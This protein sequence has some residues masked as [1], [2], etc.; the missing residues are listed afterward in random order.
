MHADREMLRRSVVRMNLWTEFGCPGQNDPQYAEYEARLAEI[1]GKQQTPALPVAPPVDTVPADCV[2]ALRTK[3]GAL[4]LPWGPYLDPASVNRMRG[5]LV[6]MI[7]QLAVMEV[8]PH[9]CR[10]D[11]LTRAIRGPLSDLLPNLHYFRQRLDAARTEERARKA[12][13]ARSWPLT[14]FDDRGMR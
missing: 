11:V 2:G 7:E 14:G 12:A 1:D 4:Y 5:E 6:A 3:S 9:E 8:W 13:A 10:D